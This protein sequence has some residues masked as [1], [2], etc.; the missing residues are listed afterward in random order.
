ME[1][2]PEIFVSLAFVFPRIIPFEI[3]IRVTQN[4]PHFPF[5][6]ALFLIYMIYIIVRFIKNI[7]MQLISLLYANRNRVVI[8]NIR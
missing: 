5:L 2:F 8:W 6:I 7:Y 1:I 4:I 3:T